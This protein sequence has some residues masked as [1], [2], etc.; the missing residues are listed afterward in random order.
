[1]KC[2]KDS[3]TFVKLRNIIFKK[4]DMKPSFSLLKET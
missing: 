2:K 1:M 3:P 4:R